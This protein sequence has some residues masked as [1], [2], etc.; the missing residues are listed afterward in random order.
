MAAPIYTQDQVAAMIAMP[1]YVEHDAWEKRFDGRLGN[2]EERNRIKAQ[3]ADEKDLTEFVIEICRCIARGEASFT[4]FGKLLGYTEH[5]LCRYEIQCS[6]HTNPK[7]FSPS[8]FGSFIPHKHIYNE[9]AVR[10]DYSWDKCAEP[11]R[12]S[13]PRKKRKLTITQWIDRIGPHFL[14]DANIEISDPRAMPLFG[15]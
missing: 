10:E 13:L 1:K 9:R 7:W 5:P 8:M 4:L 14:K 3:P 12:M 2:D 15:R 6:R 11:L